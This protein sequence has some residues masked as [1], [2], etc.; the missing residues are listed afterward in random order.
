M[1]ESI[2]AFYAFALY[3]WNGWIVATFLLGMLAGAIAVPFTKE[4]YKHIAQHKQ[5]YNKDGS[6]KKQ[7]QRGSDDNKT[8]L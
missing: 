2:I 8:L 3:F 4:T 7:N 5:M 1:A 6:R